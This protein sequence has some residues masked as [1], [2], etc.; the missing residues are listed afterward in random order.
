[1]GG[2]EARG[3][4]Q[5]VSAW[6]P[7][8]TTAALSPLVPCLYLGTLKE[9]ACHTLA[10]LPAAS[11]LGTVLWPLC[12]VSAQGARR[13]LVSG[14][15]ICGVLA[16]SSAVWASWVA[17]RTVQDRTSVTKATLSGPAQTGEG[18][19]WDTGA[20]NYSPGLSLPGNSPWTLR[21]VLSTR[22]SPPL[23]LGGEQV[24]QGRGVLEGD[25]GG[26]KN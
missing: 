8:L 7:A 13:V 14:S 21:P 9:E 25:I 20:S 5:S 23:P 26:E 22:C 19:C 11:T 15:G 24:R 3:R 1:M 16:A 6:P 17:G 10:V 2:G 4:G 18:A 12:S